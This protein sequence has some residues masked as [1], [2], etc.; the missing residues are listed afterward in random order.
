MV[1]RN[2]SVAANFMPPSMFG[3]INYLTVF[4]GI[5]LSR[6]VKGVNCRLT[7]VK[8][9]TRQHVL[10][11]CR[12]VVCKAA[13]SGP[14]Q[15]ALI[16]DHASTLWW[17]L[18][19]FKQTSQSKFMSITLL[20]LTLAGLASLAVGHVVEYVLHG[21]A[22]GQSAGP[23]LPICLLPPLALMCV[24]QQDQLLLNEFAFLWVGCRAR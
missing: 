2:S 12:R 21:A 5:L 18:P 9:A 8:P 23:D 16:T 17:Q 7:E 20:S 10:L 6:K 1:T 14:T 3:S 19:T 11:C 22:V 13:G 4:T 15:Q 24:E